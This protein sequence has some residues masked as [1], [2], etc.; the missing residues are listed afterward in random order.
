MDGCVHRTDT[1]E[2]PEDAD[3]GIKQRHVV[4]MLIIIIFYLRVAPLLLKKSQD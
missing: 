2:R 3:D 1:S 4:V